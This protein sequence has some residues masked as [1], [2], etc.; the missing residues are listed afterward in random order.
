MNLKATVLR[1]ALASAARSV[2][3]TTGA[4]ARRR[5]PRPPG[6][7]RLEGVRPRP[8]AGAD[9]SCASP[10]NPD[11]DQ[12]MADVLAG[13][14]TEANQAIAGPAC[15]SDRRHAGRYRVALSRR[16][17]RDL[18]SLARKQIAAPVACAT[19][20]APPTRCAAGA[21]GPDRD[22]TQVP[23]L[24]EFLDAVKRNDALAVELFI[25]GSGVN[26]ARRTGRAGRRSKSRAPTATSAWRQLL[27]R[28]LPAAR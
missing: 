9:P 23:R 27:A 21:Q 15:R 17:G 28:S 24:D 8:D 11:P 5:R 16:S 20:P 7:R 13:R 10:R 26:S 6:R 25:A 22:G 2:R 18:V 14:N 1:G 4:R 19:P 12:A 3:R